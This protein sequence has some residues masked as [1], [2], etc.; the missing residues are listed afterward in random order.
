MSYDNNDVTIYNGPPLFGMR[1]VV[2]KFFVNWMRFIFISIWERKRN[3]K[4]VI[5]PSSQESSESASDNTINPLLAY[6]KIPRKAVEYIMET[7]P[8]VKQG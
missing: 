8:I 1:S 3:G 6:F 5:I 4:R 7:F 2:L